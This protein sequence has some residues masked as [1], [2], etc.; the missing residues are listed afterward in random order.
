MDELEKEQG[1]LSVKTNYDGAIGEV[2]KLIDDLTRTREAIAAEPSTAL[3]PLVKVSQRVPEAF[4][5]A[6]SNLKQVNTVLKG[7][8]KSLGKVS[9][10]PLDTA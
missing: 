6:G 9:I 10:I 3:L 7:Y 1:R 2:Q 4:R 5:E 8:E